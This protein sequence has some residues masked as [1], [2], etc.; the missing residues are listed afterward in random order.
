MNATAQQLDV[1]EGF[2][3]N[4][5]GHLIPVDTIKPIDLARDSLV[6]ELIEGAKAQNKALA[7]F[8][9]G[10]FADVAA[11]VTLSAE[12]YE[13]KLGGKKGN[14]T[15]VSFDGR[16]KVNVAT[17]ENIT[18]DERLQ[19]A[20]GLIDE[21]IHDWSRDSGPEI[22]VIVQQAFDTD[23]EGNIST[24]RIL[25][26]RRLDIKDER[27]QRAMQAIGESVQVIGTS[28]YVRFYERVG[29]T[30]QYQPISL[31]VAKV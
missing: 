27:W 29:S 15:L 9:A 20:K 31:D 3:K 7:Q 8:K 25:G 5:Q 17:A 1:P 22:K 23:K 18:F 21:C 11:F 28:Q 26:L 14:V 4:A 12:Q 30:D 6:Q 24:G 16:Y 13:A 19:A 2:R 10:V